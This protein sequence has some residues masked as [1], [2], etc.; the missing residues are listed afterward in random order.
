MKANIQGQV[1]KK[2]LFNLGEYNCSGATD[3]FSSSRRDQ[4]V[5]EGRGYMRRNPSV[6]TF[7]RQM[8]QSSQISARQVLAGL[9]MPAA[10]CAPDG[11]LMVAKGSD[12]WPSA[13]PFPARLLL[14]QRAYIRRLTCTWQS[15]ICRTSTGLAGVKMSG[16]AVSGRGADALVDLLTMLSM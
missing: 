13:V 16:G 1:L 12:R 2:G 11:R 14:T 3:R 8:Q 5:L 6:Q 9:H 15:V 4:S 7:G 10:D